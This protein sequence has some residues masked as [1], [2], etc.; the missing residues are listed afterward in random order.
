MAGEITYTE[1]NFEI[2]LVVF[3][4]NVTTIHAITYTNA[5]QIN[6]CRDFK[7]PR[8]FVS[9]SVDMYGSFV[10]KDE[11]VEWLTWQK[12]YFREKAY[13]ELSSSSRNKPFVIKHITYQENLF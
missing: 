7:S 6:P 2:S 3:M 12:V 8:A 4:P 13:P 10:Q 1:F 11:E 5:E 9:Q